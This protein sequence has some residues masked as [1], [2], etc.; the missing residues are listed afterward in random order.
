MKCIFAFITASFFILN[1]TALNYTLIS[2][3][4]NPSKL[5]KIFYDPYEHTVVM[6]GPSSKNATA[7]KAYNW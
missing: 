7:Y 1:S 5:T 6:Y 3:L 2:S 4:N